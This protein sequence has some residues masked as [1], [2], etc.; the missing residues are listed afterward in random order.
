MGPRDS[1]EK[2]ATD[3]LTLPCWRRRIFNLPGERPVL[4]WFAEEYACAKAMLFA[5]EGGAAII[6]VDVPDAIIGLAVDEYFP[7]EQG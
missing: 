4:V 2:I 3:G 6:E 5:N 7:L 1:G